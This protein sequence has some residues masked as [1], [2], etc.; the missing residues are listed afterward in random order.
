MKEDGKCRWLDNA[1]IFTIPAFY[2]QIS[3]L[4]VDFLGMKRVNFYPFGA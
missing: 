3:Y 4:P 1:P 2:P